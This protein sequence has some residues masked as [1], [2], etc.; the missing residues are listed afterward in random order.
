MIVLK[1]FQHLGFTVHLY[2]F[3]SNYGS[4]LH[5]HSETFMS[6]PQTT[7]IYDFWYVVAL[8]LLQKQKHAN[9]QN[10]RKL[11]KHHH[12]FN[13]TAFRKM[14]QSE[15]YQIQKAMSTL[16]STKPHILPHFPVNL[17]RADLKNFMSHK[18]CDFTHFP[19]FFKAMNVLSNW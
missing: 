2:I 7:A 3:W 1:Y 10:T 6:G 11:G 18:P 17:Q 9:R 12:Q 15:T 4:T 14:L 19:A 8:I 5:S 16:D 13:K